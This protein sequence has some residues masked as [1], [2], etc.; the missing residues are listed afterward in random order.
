MQNL[1]PELYWLTLTALMTGLLWIPYI[2]Q[3]MVELGI[4]GALGNLPQDHFEKAP[5]AM[6]LKQAH[7]NA[8]ENLVVFAP[9]ALAVHIA[10][11]GNAATAT[12]CAIYFFARLAHVVVHAAGIPVVRTLAFVIGWLVVVYLALHLLGWI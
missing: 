3:R 8:V 5:W 6:R 12:A 7:A 10:G 9:L 1:S 2:L 11:A 4:M